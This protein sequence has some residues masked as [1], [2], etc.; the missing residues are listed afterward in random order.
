[1]E[2]SQPLTGKTI[3]VTRPIS[4]ADDFIREIERLG[5]QA[6]HFPTIKIVSPI[7]WRDC[8][9]AIV[10]IHKYDGILFTSSNAVKSFIGRVEL[11]G[12]ASEI[13]NGIKLF[14]VGEKT[15]KTIESYQCKV[16]SVPETFTAES[17]AKSFVKEEIAG[18]RFLFPHGNLGRDVLIEELRKMGAEV[19]AVTVY[20]TIKPSAQ[21][22]DRIK[23]MLANKEIDVITFFSS[24][25]VKNFLE[26]L[27]NF[28][29][30]SIKIAVIGQTTA[31]AVRECGLHPDIIA[32]EATSE[33]LAIS[34]AQRINEP[35]N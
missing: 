10:N 28:E 19:D 8:D 24:S 18:K 6:I 26:L 33:S 5:G 4:E 15:R 16:A 25:S 35:M 30:N 9:E 12:K 29:Q 1:M 11:R 21:D 14:A 20:Q 22:A 7:S 2:M 34:I 27:P 13:L 31:R 32:K 23:Q 3:L 17:L